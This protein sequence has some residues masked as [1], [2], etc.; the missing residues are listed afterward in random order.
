MPASDASLSLLL[1]AATPELYRRNAFRL[2]GL[3]VTATARE[4]ARQADKLKMLAEVGGNAAYQLSVIPGMEAP[5]ADEV[6]EASQRLKDVETR[7]LDEFFWFWPDDWGK[8][9]ADEAFV[10]VKQNDLDAAFATWTQRE[11]ENENERHAVIASRNIALVLHMR[12][13]EWTLLDFTN[14]LPPER[15]AKVH[16]YWQE[17]FKRWE[18]LADDD[19][20]WDAFKARIRQVNDAALTTGFAR[21]LRSELPQAFDKINAELAL[22]YA[23]KGRRTEAQWHVDFLKST[24]AGLDDTASTIGIVLA[25]VRDR[26]ER[27]MGFARKNLQSDKKNGITHAHKLL[28]AAE[29][30]LAVMDMFHE[31]DSLERCQLFDGVAECALDCG[32]AGYNTTEQ[33][34]NARPPSPYQ[35]DPRKALADAFVAALSRAESIATDLDLRQR[36][37][38]NIRIAEGNLNFTTK[39]K[40]LLDR[41]GAIQKETSATPLE[42]L[43]R[44]KNDVIPL[45]DSLFQ[46]GVLEREAQNE[47]CNSIAI[48]LRGIALSAN[49][50]FRQPKIGMEALTLAVKYAR[51]RELIARLKQDSQTMLQNMEAASPGH[52]SQGSGKGCLWA[53]GIGLVV[54]VLI[55]QLDKPS[56]ATKPYSSNYTPPP[57]YTPTVTTPKIPAYTPPKYVSPSP[58]YEPVKPL[59]TPSPLVAPPVVTS[60]PVKTLADWQL[61]PDVWHK[62]RNHEGKEITAKIDSFDGTNVILTT[63]SNTH[64]YPLNKLSEDSQHLVREL[65][66]LRKRPKPQPLPLTSV[67]KGQV[68]QSRTTGPLVIQTRSGSGNY[69]VKLVE[70]NTGITRMTIF[71]REGATTNE[72]N[73]PAGTYEMRYA[74]GKTWYGEEALFGDE[75]TYNKADSDFNIGYGNGYTVELYL[76]QFGNLETRRLNKEN[77]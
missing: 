14:P 34:G 19:R 20:L 17:A 6:R 8:P 2:T 75:T 42:R 38:Q 59:A 25:P 73:V 32:V 68:P 28:D 4:V 44:V 51:D 21:R 5:T 67:L 62:L 46:P 24:H 31:A 37:S 22:T 54:L 61:E 1:K 35:P 9:E 39:I 16:G 69:Y 64:I 26:L 13:I 47:M 45:L 33:D 29:P 55:G 53:F 56:T 50:D 48:V 70:K 40:P 11:V 12:A 63:S 41:L 43:N 65:D 74:T 30:L 23:G 60:K 76:Q 72:L 18:W 66:R 3:M 7:A 71:V 15:I 49:N 58:A 10:A 77:F 57:S 36:I 27:A 52:G